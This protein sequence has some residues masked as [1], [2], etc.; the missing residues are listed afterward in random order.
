MKKVIRTELRT[1]DWINT[2]FL[3]IGNDGKISGLFTNDLVF[4]HPKKDYFEVEILT[5]NISYFLYLSKKFILYNA[6]IDENST[7]FLVEYENVCSSIEMDIQTSTYDFSYNT[8]D[9]E[10]QSRKSRYPI[11]GQ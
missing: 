2:G 6:Y 10:I 3:L 11:L 9:K 8:L 5:F 4:F 1:E 7:Y